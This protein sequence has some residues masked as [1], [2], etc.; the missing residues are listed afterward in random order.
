MKIAIVSVSK[1]GKNLAFDLKEKL[2]SDSTI[3]KTDL[4]HKNVKD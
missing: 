4:Y 2:N 3:I 1:K